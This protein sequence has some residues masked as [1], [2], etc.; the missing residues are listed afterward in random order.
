MY[1]VLFQF[2]IFHIYAYGFFIVVGLAIATMLAVLKIRKSNIKIS[3]ENAANLFFY[4]AL[5][6]FLG[7]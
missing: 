1:P 4:T 2:G 6:G 7:S 3:L 5:S